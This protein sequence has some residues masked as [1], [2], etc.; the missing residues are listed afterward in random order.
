M[1]AAARPSRRNR[2]ARPSAG[3][4][5]ES[6]R[7]S[8]A[9]IGRRQSGRGLEGAVERA[10]RLESGVERDGQDR[11]RA[12]S[13]VGERGARLVEPEGVDV[14]VEVAM[15]KAL[16]DVAAQPVF[17]NTEPLP[18]GRR[19]SDPSIA[20]DTLVGHQALQ[21]PRRASSAGST[22]AVPASS[23][24]PMA[25][26]LAPAAAGASRS[27]RNDSAGSRGTAPTAPCA[28]CRWPR[29]QRSRAAPRC[30]A[31]PPRPT[32]GRRRR[33]QAAASITSV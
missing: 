8:A 27:G 12:A 28:A 29:R 13:R 1:P 10:D 20:V 16:V 7:C 5:Q 11:Q 22:G 9:E 31:S 17:R 33:G 15:A 26:P 23:S 24:A 21:A 18:P 25:L 32:A 3:R 4:F 14:G 30:R 19:P 6:A 2:G